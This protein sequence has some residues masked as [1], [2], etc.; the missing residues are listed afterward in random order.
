MIPIIVFDRMERVGELKSAKEVTD[1]GETAS[2]YD[3]LVN[4]TNTEVQP[5]SGGYSECLPQAYTT[6][7]NPAQPAPPPLHHHPA[8]PT[9]TNQ[10]I[11]NQPEGG[12]YSE[13]LPQAY[14]TN[15]NP[16]QPAPPPH[17]H[18]PP[19][20]TWPA[21]NIQVQ[22]E[23]VEYWKG[24]PLAYTVNTSNSHPAPPPHNHSSFPV[25]PQQSIEIQPETAGYSE[26]PSPAYKTNSNP[27]HPPPPFSPLPPPPPHHLHPPFP[28]WPEQNIQV[29]PQSG[30]YWNGPFRQPAP[31]AMTAPSTY[32][33]PQC[34]EDAML[35]S[36]IY[37]A[38][39][40]YEQGQVRY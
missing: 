13:A 37:S 24:L 29:Q 18:D 12:E 39:Y 14:T 34:Q 17:H 19:V 11:Q 33:G 27:A 1:P 8:F 23:A 10:N 25:W 36:H 22:P 20:P 5:Q 31:Y 16:A 2:L 4:A 32:H 15:T 21:Q 9:R 30:G 6:S 38:G 40:A 35:Q 26:G 7:T 3:V 28:A